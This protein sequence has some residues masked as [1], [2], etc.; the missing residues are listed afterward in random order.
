[1][2]IILGQLNRSTISQIELVCKI[3]CAAGGW[4]H[5]FYENGTCLDL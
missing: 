5:L 2:D 3:M 1:M 4:G